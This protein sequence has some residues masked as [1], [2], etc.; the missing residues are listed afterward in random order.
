MQRFVGNSPTTER[1]TYEVVFAEPAGN[2]KWKI[3]ERANFNR[4]MDCSSYEQFQANS[5]TQAARLYWMA[6]YELTITEGR[7]KAYESLGEAILDA[8]TLPRPGSVLRTHITV[9]VR[10]A[11]KQEWH[12]VQPA[13]VIQTT[14]MEKVI[15]KQQVQVVPIQFSQLP[16]VIT[17]GT[18]R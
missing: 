17:S 8:P 11:G 10:E 12:I 6:H 7:E 18:D 3:P 1:K 2:G 4:E 9:A 15:A 14:W 16:E 5:M 13:V